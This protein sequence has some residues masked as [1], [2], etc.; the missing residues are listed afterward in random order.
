[1]DFRDL[2]LSRLAGAL[3]P[4]DLRRW[5]EPLAWEYDS[6]RGELRL[7]APTIFHQREAARHTALILAQAAE[8]GRPLKNVTVECRRPGPRSALVVTASAPGSAAPRFTVLNAAHSFQAF[9]RGPGNL[10]A[11]LAL[12]EFA[13]G[14]GLPGARSLLLVASGPWGKTHLLEALALRLAGEPHRPFLKLSGG[15]G[16]ARPLAPGFWREKELIIVDDVHLL[17]ER[18]DLQA[19]LVQAFDEAVSRSL[20]LVFS[21]PQPPAKLTA[22]SEPLRSRLGGGLVLK[23]EPPEPELMREM[24]QRRCRELGLEASPEMLGALVREARS[25]PRRLAGFLETVAFITGHSRLSLPEAMRMLSPGGAAVETK[26][27]METILSGVAAA[28]GLKVSD[29]TGHSKLRQ[30]AWPRRVAMLLAREMTNLTTTDIGEALGGRDHSTVI[31]A[32]KK[33]HEELRNPTQ[34]Q[35]VENI[36]R[37]LIISG[38]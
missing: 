36:K 29:L 13:A 32:L 12:E 28:F 15:E 16:E 33:I 30:A 8:C 17:A 11:G 22:L 34:V 2:I 26:V 3:P 9:I 27:N 1:M 38:G 35:L 4:A 5:L 18:P 6:E 20:G 10:L 21:S 31:H 23:I 14:S 19:G 25:D 37:S 7:L 24:A